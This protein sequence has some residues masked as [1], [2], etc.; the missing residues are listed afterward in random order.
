MTTLM[1]PCM[2]FMTVMFL[3]FGSA[4]DTWRE[5]VSGTLRRMAVTPGSTA[6]FL[7]GK[8]L[9]LAAIYVLIAVVALLASAFLLGTAMYSPVLVILWVVAS[10]GGFYLLL[11]LLLMSAP[12]QR[13]ASV[14]GNMAVM[15][16]AMLGGTFFPFEL[17]PD[18]MARIGRLTPNGWALDRFREIL[19]GTSSPASLAMSFALL[20]AAGG[21]L[22]LLANWRLRRGFLL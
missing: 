11:L 8:L 19:S 13:A 6:H 2:V 12:S 14:L 16:F 7:A 15:I 18:F 5:K 3:A 9:A 10:G 20:L 4:G 17:M 22:F 21:V 1:F